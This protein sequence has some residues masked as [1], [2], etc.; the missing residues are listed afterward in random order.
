MSCIPEGEPQLTPTLAIF[1]AVAA[2]EFY[3]DVFGAEELIRFQTP[4]GH[5]WSVASQIEEVPPEQ[6]LEVSRGF[7]GG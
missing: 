4:F 6:M 3:K 7:F 5:I 2:I 1:D